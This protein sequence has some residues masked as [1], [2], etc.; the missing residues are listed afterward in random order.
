MNVVTPMIKQY[1]EVKEKNPDAI[2]LYRMG[3]FYE[4]FFEDAKLASQILDITLTSRDK[5]KEGSIPLCGVPYHAVGGYIQKLVDQGYK[6]AICEQ[7]EEASKAKG[8]VRREVI[9]VITPGMV[10]E[11]ELLQPKANNFLMALALGEERMGLAYLDASTGDFLATEIQTVQSLIDEGMKIAPKEVLIAESTKGQIPVKQLMK[12]LPHVLFTTLPEKVFADGR[13]QEHM[14]SLGHPVPAAKEIALQAVGALL[15]YVQETQKVRPAHLSQV[16]FYE[17]R[18]YLVL[19]ETT[20][21]NLELFENLQTRGRKGSLLDVLDKTGT[22]MG[23]RMLRRWMSAPLMDLQTIE[24]RL[25]GVAELREKDLLRQKLREKTRQV[26]DLERLS[27][28]IS[29]GVANARDLVALR[30]SLDLFPEIKHP[31]SELQNRICRTHL[32]RWDNLAE[33]RELLTRAIEDNPPTTLKEGG[34]IKPGFDAN[35]D[36]LREM[37]TK[38]KKW[39]VELESRERLATGIGSLKVRYNR[40]FGYYI[41]VTKPNLASVPSRYIRKQTLANAE[42]FITEELQEYETQVLTAEEQKD[43]L[44]YEIFQQTLGKVSEVIPRIQKM[45]SALAEIDVLGSLADVAEQNRYCRPVLDAENHLQIREGRHPVLEQASLDERFVP[46]DLDMD[47]EARQILIITGPNMAG[48]STIMRQT[49][50]IVILAQMGSFVP[51]QE[52]RIG[53]VDRIFTRVGAT[54]DLSRGR[55]TFMVEMEEMAHILRH[56][57]PRSLILLDEVGRGTSTFDGL[58]IAWAVTEFLHDVCPLRPRTLFATHY[59]ELTELALTKERIK[60]CHVAVKEW[61]ERVIFL[62]KLVEGATSRSYGIQVAR[63]AGL[64][65]EVIDR[66]KEVLNNLEQGEFTDGGLPKLALSRKRRISWDTRQ[67]NLFQT[68]PDP[69]REALEK[70]DPD[71]L[72]PLEALNI[73]SDLKTRF[74]SGKE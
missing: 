53:L 25:D 7:M 18:D 74:S 23:G 72:T 65:E 54:D 31:F 67:M 9:R 58:S 63:L 55:S 50:L 14:Q 42:R 33:I 12:T 52:A 20:R 71:R 43:A 68:P 11:D 47:A 35:L 8:I 49:A 46:N 56:M 19:D 62:R 13:A 6:V 48:K 17:V 21:R 61:N 45:A 73:L 22:P 26:R 29:L 4:M 27:A 2:L 16:G 32:N 34:I 3:D 44:E 69:L 57:A 37:A 41:E 36:H 59:H 70:V 30:T 10:F 60:N 28:R 51:A 15:F 66:A 38:G 39:I 40:V 1:L 5:N 24:D 64:P